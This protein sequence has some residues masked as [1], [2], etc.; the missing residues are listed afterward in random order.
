MRRHEHGIER[1]EQNQ[2]QS[3]AHKFHSLAGP[4]SPGWV[5]VFRFSRWRWSHCCRLSATLGSID[6][7][8][9]AFRS[10]FAA[11]TLIAQPRMQQH[12]VKHCGIRIAWMEFAKPNA[13]TPRSL[14][15]EQNRFHDD[16]VVFNSFDT[17]LHTLSPP[18]GSHKLHTDYPSI[19]S[20]RTNH[21][22]R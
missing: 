7:R 4:P 20:N 13:S 16:F 15:Y 9:R 10:Q 6:W 19:R 12:S 22:Q 1:G 5:S 14:C 8:W 2:T 11:S 18:K 3:C 21:K 17:P